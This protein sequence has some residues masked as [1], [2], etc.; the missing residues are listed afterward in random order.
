MLKMFPSMEKE[1]EVKLGSWDLIPLW[2]FGG[3]HGK[4]RIDLF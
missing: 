3:V 2:Q 1:I 4:I